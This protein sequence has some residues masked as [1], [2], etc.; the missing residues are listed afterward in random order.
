TKPG[1]DIKTARARGNQ[2]LATG[3][4]L[5]P[6]A[7][8]GEMAP[9]V[10]RH[11]WQTPGFKK[12][13]KRMILTIIALIIALVIFVGWKFYANISRLFGGNIFGLFSTQKLRGEDSGHVNILI[14]GYSADDP[15]HQG[16]DLT[17]SIMLVS[18][19]PDNHTAF[20]VSIPRDLWVN[21]PGVGY[22]KINQAYETG[23]GNGGNTKAGMAELEHVVSNDFGL[24]VDYYALVNYQAIKDAVN[25]VG[26]IDVIIHGTDGAPGIY[27]P[28]IDYATGHVLADYSNGVHHLDGEQALDLARA[29]GDAYGSYGLAGGDFDRTMYQRQMLITLAHKAT[30]ASTLANPFT[31]SNL[32]DAVGNNVKTDFTTPE[33]HRLYDLLK[34]TN[35]SSVQSYGLNNT[36][37]QGK[38][39][40]EGFMTYGGESAQKPTAGIGNYHQIKQFINNLMNSGPPSGQ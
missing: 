17:D 5:P 35:A 38:A 3:R 7:A 22:A 2:L 27:D 32:L 14:A 9:H 4:N 28:D 15:G 12:W 30:S 8:L 10:P 19:N 11:F 40:V 20:M 33:I 18:I 21:I 25:A 13:R 31:L 24:P 23:A 26:G 16:A 34:S 36:N 29:R 39:L 6:T 1:P 37:G